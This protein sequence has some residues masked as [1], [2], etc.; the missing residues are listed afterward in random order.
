MRYGDGGSDQ[1][2]PL[3]SHRHGRELRVTVQSAHVNGLL[4]QG[5][6]MSAASRVSLSLYASL[7][8]VRNR[9]RFGGSKSVQERL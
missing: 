4:G 6:T 9:T 7:T 3:R 8:G 2:A 1:A 5:I